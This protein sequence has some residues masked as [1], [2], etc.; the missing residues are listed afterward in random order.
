[1]ADNFTERVDLPDGQ[2]GVL[3]LRYPY[4]RYL[5]IES[6]AFR[7]VDLSLIMDAVLRASLW[8]GTELRHQLTDEIIDESQVGM[9]RPETVDTLRQRA[10]E[11][12]TKWRAQAFPKGK[13]ATAPA[14]SA[15]K[16]SSD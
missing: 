15:R 2:V 9:A 3:L 1:M 7:D 5:Q 11:N 13:A 4:E 12:Y 10:F 6:A 8:E 16:A 14:R